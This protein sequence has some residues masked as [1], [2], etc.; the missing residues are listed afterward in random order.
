MPNDYIDQVKLSDNTIV[1]IKDTVSGYVEKFDIAATQ[2]TGTSYYTLNKTYQEIFS[3]ITQQKLVTISTLDDTFPY[4]T[5][6]S[7][8]I[9]FGASLIANDNGVFAATRGILVTNSNNTTLG[10]AIDS[11]YSLALASDIPTS[12]SD[13][14]AQPAITANGI[15]K[16]NGSGTITAAVVGTDYGGII[17]RWT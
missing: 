8:G 10:V 5:L 13:I 15:L 9:V 2:V 4:T 7:Y 6:T 11:N 12:A 1:D 17:R 14:G 16:G 3:A